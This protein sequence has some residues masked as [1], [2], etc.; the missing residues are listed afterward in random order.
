[1]Y[2]ACSNYRVN[3]CP[4]IIKPE[5]NIQCY[6]FWCFV[7]V[8]NFVSQLEGTTFVVVSR[9][10]GFWMWVEKSAHSGVQ[11]RTIRMRLW[12]L[13]LKLLGPVQTCQVQKTM[14]KLT[15]PDDCTLQVT[16]TYTHMNWTELT[17]LNLN[18]N[19]KPNRTLFITSWHRPRR[20]HCSFV[21]V[22][23]LRSC[24]MGWPRDRYRVNA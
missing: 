11:I 19:W 3:C 2:V 12:C 14:Q 23:L 20:K 8:R 4:N 21:V 5:W 15:Q 6:N 13:T 16:V 18:L 1:M 9:G 10:V 24:L 22:Q 17:G 7:W